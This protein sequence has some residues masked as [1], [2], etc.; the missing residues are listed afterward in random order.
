MRLLTVYSPANA[1]L[2][3]Q[4]F[5]PSLP[6]KTVLKSYQLLESGS[7]E[8]GSTHWQAGVSAKVEWAWEHL[9]ELPE[10]EAFALADAD[11]QFFPGFSLPALEDLLE[12]SGCDVLYQREFRSGLAPD[13]NTG[14][15]VAR[16]TPAFC[17][18]FEEIRQRLRR[19]DRKSDQT[20]V[21]ALLPTYPIR[22]GY[23]PGQYYARTQ[24]FPPPRDIVLHHANGTLS[25][26]LTNKIRQLRR[27]R[28]YVERGSWGRF[29][30]LMGESFDLLRE[31][32]L[33]KIGKRRR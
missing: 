10:G 12:Q 27:I 24:G 28:A 15:Y 4:F 23:L 29:T 6:D 25:N 13:V 26:S 30:A 7:S 5:Y 16:A 14:F 33:P 31:G 22:W 19:A 8:Y 1:I 18:Y 11:I 20:I 32:D 17:C 21:N 2:Y 3:D 9:Q